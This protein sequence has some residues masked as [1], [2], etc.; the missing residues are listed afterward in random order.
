MDAMEKP[1]SKGAELAGKKQ[2]YAEEKGADYQLTARLNQ[3]NALK[4]CAQRQQ[5]SKEVLISKGRVRS[6]TF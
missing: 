5:S 3:K 4:T 2:Q 6:P 1:A